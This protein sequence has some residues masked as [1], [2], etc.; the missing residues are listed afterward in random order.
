MGGGFRGHGGGFHGGFHGG[1]FQ[2]GFH[3]GGFQRGFHGGGFQRGFHGGGFHRGFHGGGFRGFHGGGFHR[4]FHGGGFF[5]YP[6]FWGYPVYPLYNYP[7]YSYPAYPYAYGYGNYVQPEA[8]NVTIVVPPQA[9]APPVNVYEQPEPTQPMIREYP[10]YGEERKGEAEQSSVRTY[11]AP[12]SSRPSPPEEIRFLI[13]LKD[14][15][16]YTAVAY[17]VEGDMLHYITTDGRHNQVSLDLVDR[18][19][20]ERLNRGGKAEFRLPPAKKQG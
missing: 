8:P 9:A 7:L 12:T 17:W 10:P 11:R 5:G 3:G 4:G 16:V 6:R 19:V 15:S 13:P 20:A 18:A 1:G 2:R 14:K